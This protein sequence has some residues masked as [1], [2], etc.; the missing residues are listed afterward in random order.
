MQS[1]GFHRKC[2]AKTNRSV[3]AI[4]A[5]SLQKNAASE[6]FGFDDPKLL[7]L[8]SSLKRRPSR[9]LAFEDDPEMDEFHYEQDAFE[10]EAKS[11]SK[12]TEAVTTVVASRDDSEFADTALWSESASSSFLPTPAKGEGPEQNA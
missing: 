8:L 1:F 7:K 2:Q 6:G 4:C 11:M 12:M 9:H 5:G 10:S 3:S